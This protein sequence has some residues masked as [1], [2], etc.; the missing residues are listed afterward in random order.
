MSNARVIMIDNGKIGGGNTTV[1][2]NLSGT[3]AYLGKKVL[4]IDTN[5]NGN[6]MK[7]LGFELNNIGYTIYDMMENNYPINKVI[8][9]SKVKNLDVIASDIRLLMMDLENSG[10][11]VSKQTLLKD[12]LDS[13]RDDYDFIIIDCSIQNYFYSG[14]VMSADS[15]LIPVDIY[16]HAWG[17]EDSISVYEENKELLN[18]SLE[19]E[20]IIFIKYDGKTNLALNSVEDLKKRLG[21]SV[22]YYVINSS[23]KFVES[24]EQ[25][26]PAY[27]YDLKAKATNSF[28]DF[29]QQI[30]DKYHLVKNWYNKEVVELRTELEQDGIGEI[31]KRIKRNKIN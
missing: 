4:V 16:G 14:V 25:G 31:E 18:P 19:L 21:A 6:L 7:G 20:G 24:L 12:Y 27:I 22:N 26:L 30:I 28:K 3:L 1:A 2:I 17:T 9:K 11:F 10:M 23:V 29:A 15:V 8:M 5:P 13:V